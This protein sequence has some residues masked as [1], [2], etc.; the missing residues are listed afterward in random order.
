MFG[1]ADR[2]RKAT[3]HTD[4]AEARAPPDSRSPSPA[5]AFSPASETAVDELLAE[6]LEN[7][8]AKAQRDNPIRPSTDT[9]PNL[10]VMDR[11]LPHMQP[12][13]DHNSVHA[14]E[15]TQKPVAVNVLD[16][17]RKLV[18]P[19]LLQNAIRRDPSV[20]QDR[21]RRQAET[22][23]SDKCCGEFIDLAKRAVAQMREKQEREQ[24][25]DQEDVAQGAS[26]KRTREDESGVVEQ[27]NKRYRLDSPQTSDSKSPITNANVNLLPVPHEP[28][29]IIETTIDSHTAPPVVLNEAEESNDRSIESASQMEAETTIAEHDQDS[30]HGPPSEVGPP[31]ESS[32]REDEVPIEMDQVAAVV[33]ATD[34]DRPISPPI[35]PVYGPEPPQVDGIPISSSLATIHPSPDAHLMPSTAVPIILAAVSGRSFANVLETTFDVE[36]SLIPS[37]QRWAKRDLQFE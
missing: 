28:E 25:Q 19:H 5:K 34:V 29:P 1:I 33:T 30:V 2:S 9:T 15:Q 13:A 4:D 3:S 27:S 26:T 37:L 21:L 18:M 36:E 35:S 22:L 14:D 11:S 20:D 24:R 23:F 8:V 17:C 6:V 32:H 31:L 16:E 10:N 7:D 12:S